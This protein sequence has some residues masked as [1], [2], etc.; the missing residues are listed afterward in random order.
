MFVVI[1]N[2][3]PIKE[4]KDVQFREWF[5]WSNKE[6]AKN[7]GYISR[8]LLKPVKSGSYVAIVEHESQETFMAMHNSPGHD[9]AGKRVAPLFDGNPTPKFYEVIVE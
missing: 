4:D 8:R 2:F 7:K 6:F 9:E 1:I 5:S 3:P